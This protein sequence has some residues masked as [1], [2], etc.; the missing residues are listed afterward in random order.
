[1]LLKDH[2]INKT[3]MKEPKQQA[4]IRNEQSSAPRSKATH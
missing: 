4:L 1:M 2:D 3:D